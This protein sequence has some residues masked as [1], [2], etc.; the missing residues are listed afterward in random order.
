MKRDEIILKFVL[1]LEIGNDVHDLETLHISII[2]PFT[3]TFQL[4]VV[5]RYLKC[6]IC[7]KI[8]HKGTIDMTKNSHQNTHRNRSKKF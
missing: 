7:D 3:D 1:I 2:A 6:V 4:Y 8:V 5:K